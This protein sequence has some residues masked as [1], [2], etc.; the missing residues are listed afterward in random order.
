MNGEVLV[1]F[2]VG[3]RQVIELVLPYGFLDCHDA[4]QAHADGHQARSLTLG[5]TKWCVD[6]RARLL[7]LAA[8]GEVITCHLTRFEGGNRIEAWQCRVS[9]YVP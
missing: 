3:K 4:G 5:V 7:G 1:F 9:S 2:P 6:V 8:A